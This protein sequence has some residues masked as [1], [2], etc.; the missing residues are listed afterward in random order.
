MSPV[1]LDTPTSV[2]ALCHDVYS[3]FPP[4]HSGF[5]VTT[6]DCVP[7][8][9]NHRLTRGR[10]HN[11]LLSL[12]QSSRLSKYNWGAPLLI[13]WQIISFWRSPSTQFKEQYWRTRSL[14]FTVNDE[15]ISFWEIKFG[16][17]REFMIAKERGVHEL[18]GGGKGRGRAAKIETDPR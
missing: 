13:N 7:P 12:E 6:S 17:Y 14:V 9:N 5:I 1:S 18:R 11:H 4:S 15:N 16:K 10:R 2:T 3:G 8:L